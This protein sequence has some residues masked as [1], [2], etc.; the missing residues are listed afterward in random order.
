MFK[1][2]GENM[3]FDLPDKIR[4]YLEKV[5]KPLDEQIKKKKSKAIIE[6]DFLLVTHRIN[7]I[8]EKI[9]GI[10]SHGSKTDAER[11][12]TFAMLIDLL[13]V[14]L[15]NIIFIFC[16]TAAGWSELNKL[17]KPQN[18]KLS[19]LMKDIHQF[20]KKFIPRHKKG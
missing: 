20:G 1:L 9:Y 8:L 15:S 17:T 11:E 7:M 13:L 16:I 10:I 3:T 18:K 19:R 2:N 4:K 14:L 12:A 5:S 6:N